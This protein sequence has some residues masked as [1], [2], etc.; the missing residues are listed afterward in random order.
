MDDSKFQNSQTN[1]SQYTGTF[2]Q[3]QSHITGQSSGA[4]GGSSNNNQ[5][6]E[7]DEEVQKAYPQLIQLIKDS[8]SM[9]N[10]ERYYWFQTL[11]IMTDEQI[12]SLK[13]ILTNEKN[14]LTS[15][16][17]THQ[18]EI[19][20]ISQKQME[21]WNIYEQKK[22]DKARIDA[23]KKEEAIEEKMEEDILKEL[24]NL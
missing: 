3:T 24:E 18:T 6:Y 2:N 10:D 1:Q 4:T 23:E 13:N 14:K 7:I 19:N 16:N 22:K 21:S 12:T 9:S 11:S 8:E 17:K 20:N 5:D 15:I